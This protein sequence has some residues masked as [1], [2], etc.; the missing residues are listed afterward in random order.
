MES[1]FDLLKKKRLDKGNLKRDQFVKF[2]D[3]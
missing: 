3:K 1:K 2:V